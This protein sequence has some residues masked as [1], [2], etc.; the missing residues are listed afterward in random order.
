VEQ[1][2]YLQRL[3]E[4]D[5]A[6]ERARLEPAVIVERAAGLLA[7][8]VGSRV[9]E[10]HSYL[11]H[12][13]TQEGRPVA[14]LAAEVRGALESTTVAAPGGFDSAVDSAVDQA[15]RPPRRPVRR[16]RRTAAEAPSDDWA[17]ALQQVLSGLPDQ[18]TVVLP[19]HGDAGEVV[20]FVFAAA[21][22]AMVDT[23]GRRGEQIV[24]ARVS[25]AYPTVVDNPVW[26]AWHAVLEDGEPRQV[27]PFPYVGASERAPAEMMITVRVHPVGPGLLNTW[28]RHDEQNRLAERIAQTE[29]LGNL[30]WG[31]ADLVT[32]EIVWSDGL[33]RIYERD[34][35][36]GPLTGPE[37]DALTLPED[38]PLR[39]QAA[40]GF[41]RGETIDLTARIRLGDRIKHLR[42]VIDAVR[43]VQGRPL[44]VYGIVQDVTAQE[45]S[46]A[47]LADVERQLREH[48]RTLAAEHELAAQLQ[49][50]VLPVPAAPFELSGLRVAVKYLPA[51]EA[52]R[53]GGDWFHAAAAEDGS[54]V[55]AVGDVAGHGMQAA[56]TMA[57]LRQMV[58][59]LVI[60]TTTDPAELL[61]HLNRLLY[62]GG[63]TATAVVGRYDPATRTVLW[64]QA[65]HPAPLHTRAGST[66]KLA[67]PK[68]PLLGA[69]RGTEYGTAA[70]TL[71]D[72]DLL[73]LYTDG[74]IEHRSHTAAEGLAP[75]V[76]TLDRISASR[77]D[78][79]LADLLAQLRRAN[80]EDD[81]CI[82]AVRRSAVA[83]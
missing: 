20:D 76:A 37:Q 19:V 60:T 81:T 13:A 23:S 10:A 29:R 32:G 78:Q 80:P 25:E 68:G 82:L 56:T 53:V 33:Y 38:E 64:A 70:L 8:R 74:L 24:G 41:G 63:Q 67:R 22:P 39:R 36:L 59:G 46:R 15:L 27:G 28:V 9:D 11:L 72:G 77:S 62:A 49:Q 40:A 2:D 83:S 43:D 31:A 26:H 50:I 7:G 3:A 18:H 1:Q 55:L 17:R 35:A 48:R 66:T 69:V 51:E 79:P 42:S 73:M 21:S 75:V 61:A 52:S 34:P 57:Q 54:V 45:T 12:R 5:A 4:I 14:A 65:G 58:A 16:P 30:G 47:K 71:D 44:K 6:V